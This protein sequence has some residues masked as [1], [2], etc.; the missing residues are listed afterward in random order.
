MFCYLK[1]KKKKNW[2]NILTPNS[3]GA[4]IFPPLESLG[5]NNFGI[6]W[7]GEESHWKTFGTTGVP[8]WHGFV[9]VCRMRL[10]SQRRVCLWA[11][12]RG[13]FWEAAFLLR[14]PWGR[15][16]F[17]EDDFFFLVVLQELEPFKATWHHLWPWEFWIKQEALSVQRTRVRFRGCLEMMSKPESD[18]KA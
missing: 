7:P 16:E 4:L 5:W 3:L 6:L 8:L 12:L 17:K 10:G 13:L 1:K 14:T 2:K 15:T 9:R 11:V 18:V